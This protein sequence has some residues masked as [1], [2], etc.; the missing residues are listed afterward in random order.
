M[1]NL[2]IFSH[3]HLCTPQLKRILLH[4]PSDTLSGQPQPLPPGPVPTPV[5]ARRR[6]PRVRAPIRARWAPIPAPRLVA[7]QLPTHRG[8]MAPDPPSDLSPGQPRAP[9]RGDLLP[10]D[11]RQ[12]PTRGLAKISDHPASLGHPPLRARLRHT[13]RRGRLGHR[14]PRDP[15]PPKHPNPR[16]RHPPS[17]SHTHHPRTDRV[18]RRPL[19][20]TMLDHRPGWSVRFAAPG[21]ATD[22]AG[23][24]NGG[25]GTRSS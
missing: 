10:L 20:S 16:T 24:G 1:T 5:R 17:T 23:R 12:I 13:H 6:S 9:T 2:S 18:L 11:Q 15:R 14:R 8:A 4:R 21:G 19:E 22:P 25:R 7:G 3:G